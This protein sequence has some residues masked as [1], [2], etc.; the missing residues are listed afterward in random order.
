MRRAAIRKTQTS[1]LLLAILS[2][3]VLAQF[4]SAP[5]INWFGQAGL[6]HTESARSLG[7][8]R[9]VLG[10]HGDMS[11]DNAFC[12][13]AVVD[14][15]HF[16][17]TPAPQSYEYSVY[18]YIGIGLA[19]ILDFSAM[20]PVYFDKMPSYDYSPEYKTKFGGVQAG[21][22]DCELKLKLQVPPHNHPRLADL[23]FSVGVGLP[24]GDREHGFFPRHSYYFLRDSTVFTSHGD[25]V[26][27]RA[28][29]FSSGSPEI[30]VRMLVTLNGGEKPEFTHFMAHLNYGL[31][32]F[33]QRGFDQ[34]FLFNAALEYH[35]TQWAGC[36]AEL[37]AEPRLNRLLDGF[38]IG[39]DPLRLTPGLSI[40]PI[41]GM[42]LTISSDIGLSSQ[43][44]NL[45]KAQNAVLSSRVQP[46][47][48]LC[49]SIGWAGFL[50]RSWT[51]GNEIVTK[52]GK[53][54]D[55][56]GI[57]DTLD[58][59]PYAAED[60][61]GF[62]DDDGCPDFDNDK[63]GIPDS[64]D[65]CPNAPEDFDG[66]EDADGCPDPDNDKDGVCDPWVAEK[67]QQNLYGNTCAGSDKCPNLGEDIDG[68]EDSDGCPDPDNDL[69]GIPDTLDRCPNEA[70]SAENNGCAKSSG[71]SVSQQQGQ[72][73]AA[74]KE[75]RR[76]RLILKGVEFKQGTADLAAESFVT[77]DNVYESLKAYPEVRIEIAGYTDNTG[78]SLANRKLSQ[79][80]ADKVREYL[81][82]HGIEP[83]RIIA[84]GRGNDDPI[85]DNGTPEGRAFNRRIEMKRID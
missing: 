45:Y 64:I 42:F 41:G 25:S 23:G 27:G 17:V 71:S 20:L 24:T 9:F 74:A 48:R 73:Q 59:C 69:D 4:E 31:R 82:L 39:H 76:G 72:G 63:D 81:F 8:G 78:N 54:P 26:A 66:F 19:K 58:K 44:V 7:F 53:D 33:T 62:Q 83:S 11:L 43:D 16:A 32:M 77:L 79:R 70:G 5:I 10:A 35:P 2:A 15:P 80:R 85:A 28:G 51:G 49:A 18:P 29:F 60:M 37:S 30:D 38:D 75:I 67:G 22:G 56:D 55:N 50:R 68:F 46:G 47:F 1:G 34:V 3:G 84:V 21:I 40:T 65:Q 36:F 14:S 6:E 61:D 12:T 13:R 52:P 57:K